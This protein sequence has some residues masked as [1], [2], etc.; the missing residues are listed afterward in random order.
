MIAE[1]EAPVRVAM[2]MFVAWPVVASVTLRQV[3][4]DGSNVPM[5]RP[6]TLR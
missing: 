3:D 4:R 5:T 6:S 2:V 1:H